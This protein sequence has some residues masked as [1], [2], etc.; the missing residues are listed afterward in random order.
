M[1]TSKDELYLL[2]L[3]GEAADVIMSFY[4]GS[5]ETSRKEDF[6]PLTEA[7][8]ASHRL[9][10][11]A[12]QKRWPH[13]PV[14]S[15]EGS[16]VEFEN[17][18]GWEYFWLVD[19]LDGTKEFIHGEDEFTINVALIKR[20][21]PC[22]GI[23][24]VP[25]TKRAYLGHEGKGAYLLQDGSRTPLKPSVKRGGG[26]V[27]VAVSRFHLD[28]KTRAFLESFNDLCEPVIR[29]SALKFCSVAEGSVDL[30]LRF[31]PTWE[32]DT[33]AGQAVVEAAGGSVI[34]I[35]SEQ[36]L[37]YNKPDLKNGP[38]IVVPD[39][40]SYFHSSFRRWITSEDL[41]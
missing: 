29:G 5:Y 13:I 24:Y 39:K 33:A 6:S 41:A 17:R 40:N 28:K 9:I 11:G 38:F 10:V 21:K 23:V 3:C 34:A 18:K 1:I 22:F 30:Y 2:D 37:T 4:R 26:K 27:R 35:P 19:P 36:E 15:E 12:L 7:D 16:S 31:G 14:I 8:K 25:V 32:W 20:T